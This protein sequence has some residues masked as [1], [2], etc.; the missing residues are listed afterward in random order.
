MNQVH[1]IY[2]ALYF[3]SSAA[4]DLTGGTGLQPRGGGPLI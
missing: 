2:H 3:Y 1:Y 4:A